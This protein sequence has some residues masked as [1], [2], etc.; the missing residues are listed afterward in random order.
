MLSFAWFTPIFWGMGVGILAMVLHE[1]G[2]ILAAVAVG[3]RV[4]ALRFH[5]QGFYIVRDAGTPGKN[6]FISLAG[7]LTNAILLLG[8]PLSKQIFLAN[9]CCA[10]VNVL[11]I[12]GS[13]GDRAF[14]CWKQIQEARRQSTA[15]VA[16]SDTDTR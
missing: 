7:P 12:R 8:W 5:W 1:F 13:D 16:G 4:K 3:V 6:L 9:L 2:H 14:A 15:N 11:P 10:V